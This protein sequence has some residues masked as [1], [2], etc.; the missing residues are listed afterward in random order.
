[1]QKILLIIACFFLPIFIFP[2]FHSIFKLVIVGIIYELKIA[3]ALLILSLI[4]CRL[5]VYH[6]IL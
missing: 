4:A 5:L 3:I 6:S 2:D 1:M